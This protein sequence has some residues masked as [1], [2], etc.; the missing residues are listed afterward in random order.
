[1]FKNKLGIS[2]ALEPGDFELIFESIMT[3]SKDGLFVVDRD[4]VVVMVNRATEKMFEFRKTDV[5]GRNVK[6]LVKEGF[7]E[8]SVSLKVIRQKKA[9][10]L[11]QTTRYQKKILSTGIPIFDDLGEVRFVL[12]NDRDISHINMLAQSLYPDELPED[13]LRLDFSD[14][15]LASTELEKMVVKSPAMV[16][17][18]Q[19]VIQAAKFDVPMILTGDSGVGKSMI[20]RLIHQLS[21]RRNYPFIDLNCAAITPSLIESEL[22]GHESGAFTGASA[23]GKKGLFETAQDGTL[24]LDEIGEIPLPIQVKFLKFL[25]TMELIRVGGTRPV[26]INTRVI[27]AT[28][29]DLEQMVSEG[30]FRQDLYF[31]LNVVPITIPSLAERPE[32]IVPLALSFLERFNSEFHTKKEFSGAVCQVLSQYDF[33]GNVRELENLVRRLV[34]MTEKDL[35]D[36]GDLP[37]M[38]S[39]SVPVMPPDSSEGPGYQ[40][41]V[42]AF[43]FRRLTEAVEQ[44]GSQ[45]KAAKALGISQ[46]TLSRKLKKGRPDSP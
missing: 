29:Q 40:D 27:V 37:P 13:A 20:A 9:I 36:L 17:V 4:G 23:T 24:F 6:D 44:Y 5:L 38:S 41:E 26:K 14:I 11:I 8:P 25:E 21:R 43:E 34:T 1:M 15:D 30:S 46:A 12:V 33:P 32:D 18:I 39:G 19:T 3:H 35:I 22:F 10:S 7:Y 31:R 28:N 42:A 2:S 16:K 45:R